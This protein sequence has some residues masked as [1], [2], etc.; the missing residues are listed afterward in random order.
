MNRVAIGLAAVGLAAGL[1]IVIGTGLAAVFAASGK[2]Y[3]VAQA[4]AAMD[5]NPRSW[6]GRTVLVRAVAVPLGGNC[7]PS[8]P[9]C[10][11]IVLTDHDP[12]L[13]TTPTLVV[14]AARSNPYVTLLRRL[15]FVDRLLADPQQ[16]EWG[17]RV[18]YRLH[19]SAQTFTPCLAPCL[20]MQ[21]EGPVK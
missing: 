8:M 12:V 3:T 20:N 9:W 13:A 21:L 15:P 11:N 16:V 5:R 19:L 2:V 1:L 4:S 7:P 14:M 6:R 18:I 10:T 17:Q